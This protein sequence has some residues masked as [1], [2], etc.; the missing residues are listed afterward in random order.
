[1][2]IV[3]YVSFSQYSES[4]GTKKAQFVEKLCSLCYFMECN[5]EVLWLVTNSK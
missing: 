4:K 5:L 2:S 3:E 1:M